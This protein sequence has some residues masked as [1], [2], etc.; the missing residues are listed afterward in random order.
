MPAIQTSAFSH[1]RIMSGAFLPAV[2][3]WWTTS[4][5]VCAE[6]DAFQNRIA[7]ILQTHCISCHGPEMQEGGLRLDTLDGINKGGRSGPVLEPGKAAESLLIT[8]VNR[9]DELL[10]MPPE[11]KLPAEMIQALTEW[12]S[13]GAIHPDGKVFGRAKS[14]PFDLNEARQF[15]AFQ[16]AQSPVIPTVMHPEFVW[17]PIDAFIVA[18][19]ESLNLSPNGT[20]DKGTLIRRVTFDL[21][22]LPPTPQD[23]DEFLADDATDAFARRIDQLLGSQQYGEHW[24]RH[25]LDVV[26]YADSNGLDE[27][28]AHGNA[29]RYRNYVIRSLNADKPYDQFLREQIAGDLM[30]DPTIDETTRHDRLI[31]TG[32]LSMGPKVLAEGDETKLQMDILDEQLDTLGRAFMGM[33]FGCAR[34]H[35][36]KFDP[37]TQA[38]YYAMAGIF[39]ST[40]TMESLKRIAKWHE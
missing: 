6:E 11:E 36:H 14:L 7:P 17:N 20:A 18:Q 21:T 15:W 26:R 8:A 33:T 37:N 34:C 19:L 22:G 3:L 13:A 35:N 25:W 5:T 12:I 32:F 1:R 2:C 38:D 29:W 16:P 10:Q 27:N 9:T 30:Q 31:A 4:V 39:Q 28:I 23:V 40:R 24:G